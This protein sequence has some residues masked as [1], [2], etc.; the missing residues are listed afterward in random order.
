[1]VKSVASGAVLAIV[2]TL[3]GA[4]SLVQSGYIPANSDGKPTWLE[5]WMAQT[6]ALGSM[7]DMVCSGGSAAGKIGIIHLK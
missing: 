7:F 2:I 5:L 1:M 4:Y 3:I 6:F